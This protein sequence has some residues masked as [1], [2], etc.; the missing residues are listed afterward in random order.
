VTDTELDK[1]IRK[2][3]D[4]SGGSHSLSEE[5]NT[6]LLKAFCQ[7]KPPVIPE[8]EYRMELIVLSSGGRKGGVSIKPGNVTLNWRKLIGSLP[9]IVLTGAG[10]ATN[11][12]LFILGA[13]VIWRDLY[14]TSRVELSPQHATTILTMWNNHDGSKRISEDKARTLTNKALAEFDLNLVSETTFAII[15]DDLSQSGCVELSDGEIWLREWIR[16]SCS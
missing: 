15:I 10:A 13:L 11:P 16:R 7:V 8:A 14:S 6:N 5:Q 2:L 4:V 3:E 1:L 9:G 12:W